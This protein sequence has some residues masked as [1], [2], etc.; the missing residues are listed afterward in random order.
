MYLLV[1]YYFL[2]VR[3]TSLGGHF[4]TLVLL[5][6]TPENTQNERLN[7][8]YVIMYIPNLPIFFSY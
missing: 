7:L 6:K 1:Q 5:E 8:M 4:L 3:S 2:Q